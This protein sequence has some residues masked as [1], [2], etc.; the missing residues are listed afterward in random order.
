METE[1]KNYDPEFSVG[2]KFKYKSSVKSFSLTDLRG[3]EHFV[4]DVDKVSLKIVDFFQGK[5]KEYKVM[6]YYD[7]KELLTKWYFENE[8]THAYAL[9]YIVEVK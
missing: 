2:E 6:F 4:P 9:G 3:N 8:L 7:K 1:I 5:E